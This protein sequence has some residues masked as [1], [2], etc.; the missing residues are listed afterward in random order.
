MR[1]PILMTLA[2]LTSLFV[3][4]VQTGCCQ[5]DPAL[6]NAFCHNQND[7]TA[8]CF[9]S[10]FNFCT[11]ECNNQVECKVREGITILANQIFNQFCNIG[12]GAGAGATHFLI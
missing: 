8:A 10:N 12:A 3:D 9:N 6:G 2:I 5:R 11:T 4:V 7:Y 1:M